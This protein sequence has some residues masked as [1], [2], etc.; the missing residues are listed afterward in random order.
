MVKLSHMA[1]FI[2]FRNRTLSHMAY[3][4][5]LL[6]HMEDVAYLSYILSYIDS[7]DQALARAVGRYVF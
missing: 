4:M 7:V 3:C 2:V 6:N 1:Y 5:V